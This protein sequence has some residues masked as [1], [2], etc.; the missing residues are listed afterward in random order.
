MGIVPGNSRAMEQYVWRCYWIVGSAYAITLLHTGAFV[1]RLLP[2][3]ARPMQSI[4]KSVACNVRWRGRFDT[5]E[6]GVS[7][8]QDMQERA[9]NG[10]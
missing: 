1:A 2:R 5:N 6:G 8:K 9:V 3:A 4:N 7:K 10:R